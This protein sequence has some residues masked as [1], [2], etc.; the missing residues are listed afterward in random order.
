MKDY[1]YNLSCQIQALTGK[2]RNREAESSVESITCQLGPDRHI[3]APCKRGGVLRLVGTDRATGWERAARGRPLAGRSARAV[4]LGFSKEVQ[5]VNEAC[6]Q[7]PAERDAAPGQNPRP[8]SSSLIDWRTLRDR[9]VAAYP[10]DFDGFDC[11]R[12]TAPA[13]ELNAR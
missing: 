10:A 13:R 6:G 12:D 8:A 7:A 4:R 2:G 9:L 3:D 1:F 5:S 11:E